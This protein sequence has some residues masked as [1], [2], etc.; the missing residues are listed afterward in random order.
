MKAWKQVVH[1]LIIS[2]IDYCNSLF[3]GLP[4]TDIKKLQCV[5]SMAAKL[6]LRKQKYDSV[7]ACLKE[8]HWLTVNLRI[9]FE[10]MM[11]VWKC[12]NGQAPSYFVE[13]IHLV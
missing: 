9:E 4:K 3:Y 10:I 1:G 13:L 2:H 5:Q 11:M 7:T 8:L 6:I 12:L